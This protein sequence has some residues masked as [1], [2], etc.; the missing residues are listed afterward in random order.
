[1][2][3]NTKVLFI[4]TLPFYT[5]LIGLIVQAEDVASKDKDIPN[6]LI[7]WPVDTK[8]IKKISSTF[9]ESRYDHFHNGIDIPGENILVY[10]LEKGRLLWLRNKIRRLNE[11]Q[12]GGGKTIVLD[13][14]KFWSGYM[15]LN[16]ISPQIDSEEIIKRESKIGRS[17]K[18][19]HSGGAHLH[20]F[21]YEPIKKRIYNPLYFVGENIIQDRKPPVFKGYY[22]I[23]SDPSNP[24][25]NRYLFIDLKD[26][27]I[28]QEKWGVFYLKIFNDKK[29]IIRDIQFDFIEFK[30]YQW[31]S[32][33]GHPFSEIF[34]GP[35][36][37]L[38][39]TTKKS[40]YWEAGGFSGP[41]LKKDYKPKNR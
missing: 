1:M 31:Q 11:V 25:N 18:T 5:L 17:G 14:K 22:K 30:N 41:S 26:Q 16:S 9:G 37:F 39:N 29:N 19:G 38:S 3:H 7:Q 8:K 12:F 15:H 10:P 24:K 32:S 27:G 33:Q 4:I 2:Y 40:I 35:Y 28:A 36:Y 34:Y 6:F 23:N 13:H 21:I 20:F